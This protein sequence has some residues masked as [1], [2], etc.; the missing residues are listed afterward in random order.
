MSPGVTSLPAASTTFAAEPA[1]IPASTAA[2]FPLFTATSS[3]PLKPEPGSTTSPPLISRS[4]AFPFATIPPFD[5]LHSTFLCFVPD[6]A[7]DVDGGQLDRAFDSLWP[8]HSDDRDGDARIEHRKLQCRGCQRHAI[9]IANRAYL[10]GPLDHL[11][12]CLLV[13]IAGIGIWSA[14]EH[15]AAVWRR[16][17]DGQTAC[18]RGVDQGIGIGIQ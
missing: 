1:S 18:R 11:L 3:W 14:R 4:Y 13:G 5:I 9:A 7:R 2:I 6:L 10:L 17:Q 8:A 12:R 16:V 15:A